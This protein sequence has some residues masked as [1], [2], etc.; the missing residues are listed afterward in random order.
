MD[1]SDFLPNDLKKDFASRNLEI[2]TVLR[3]AVKDTNP[4]KIKRF[5]VVG[6]TIDGLSL[7]SVYINSNINPKVN[8]N[9]ELQKLNVPLKSI[10][11][12]FLD[13]NSFVDC[14]KLV[15][16]NSDEISEIIKNNPKAVKGELKENDLQLILE[17]LR[18]SETI[19]GKHKKK[20]GLLF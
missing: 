12:D 8:W 6:K 7:A 16:R 13:K 1:L 17:T 11:N 9:F 5:I 18:N 14:S 4:P 3:L 2:G 10:G 19:K 20:F 15:I